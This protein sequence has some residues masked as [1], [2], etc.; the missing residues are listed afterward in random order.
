MTKRCVYC[1]GDYPVPVELH[2]SEGECLGRPYPT[3]TWCRD[4]VH[5]H[6]WANDR[7][8]CA[9]GVKC[10]LVPVGGI[11]YQAA[12]DEFKRLTAGGVQAVHPDT[13]R[14]VVDAALGNGDSD[15]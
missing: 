13:I 4:P 5:D 1:K 15:G 14:A 12:A 10:L 2:H 7:L 9:D 6:V 8:A 3:I 11:D